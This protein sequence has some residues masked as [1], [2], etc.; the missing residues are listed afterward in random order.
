MRDSSLFSDLYEQKR[1]DEAHSLCDKEIEEDRENYRAL[2]NKAKL[3]ARQKN[4]PE[5]IS[6]IDEAISF[7]KEPVLFF[8]KSRWLLE[9]QDYHDAIIFAEEGIQSGNE[10]SYYYYEESLYLIKAYAQAHVGQLD[11]CI[12]SLRNIGE[13]VTIRVDR[14]V[15]SKRSIL[16]DIQQ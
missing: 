3:F 11:A 5:C 15:Y 4:W 1:Y 9:F 16:G 7:K 2:H 8:N 10:N 14:K 13:K 6:Y 12:L